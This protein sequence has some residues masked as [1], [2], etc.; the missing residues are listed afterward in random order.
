[1]PGCATFDDETCASSDQITANKNVSERRW[2]TPNPND[3]KYKKSYQNY[4][5]LVGYADVRYTD[6]TRTEAQVCI[7]ATH[8]NNANLVYKFNGISQYENCKTFNS[9]FVKEVNFN[10]EG[11]DES[12]LE[13]PPIHFLW[14]AN[15]I[16]DTQGDFRKGQK[17]AI[18]EFFGWPHN[19]LEKECELLSMAGYLGAKL[20]PVHEQ[21]MS[22]R[23]E[24]ISGTLNPYYFMNQPVSYNLDGRMGT[25]EQLASLINTCRSKGVRIYVD[26]VLNHF[27]VAG[28]D[29]QDHRSDKVNNKCTEWGP[30]TSSAPYERQSP[31]FTHNSTY[32]NNFNSK[33]PPSNEFPGA[34]IGPEHF[35]C[36]RLVSPNSSSLFELNNG[37]ILSLTDLDTSQDYVRERQAAYLVELLSLGVSGFGINYAKFMSFIACKG[38][39]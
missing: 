8:K 11:S 26:V 4:H 14:N 24:V 39:C 2:Q 5:V 9:S 15:T 6:T 38:A 19:D 12:M 7:L 37:W 16:T 25:R 28:N 17:G 18:V 21:L 27:T 3:E 30:R 32:E 35:H 23:P 20:F 33:N 34:A 13:I 36:T 10:V 22:D 1:L 29:V 31:F